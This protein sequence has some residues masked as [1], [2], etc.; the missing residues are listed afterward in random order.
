MIGDYEGTVLIVSH[1][2]DFLDR[3]VT[4]TLGL[5]GSGQV[6][7][8]AGGYEDWERRRRPRVDAKKPAKTVAAPVA[9]APARKLTYK[10]QR[11]Y[12][13]L[14]KRIE[15][16]DAA[17]ARDEAAMAD[18]D[19][20]VRD[21]KTFARLTDAIAKARADKD[22]AELRWL[23]EVW[24]CLDKGFHYRRCPAH[25]GGLAPTARLQIWRGRR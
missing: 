15:E 9:S 17:I 14:P 3:T 12:D 4:V 19:L 18:P 20:Y 16:L 21:P 11:D 13:L 7:I 23:D 6:D 25:Q 8:V 5:D 24:I 2:R 10:D 1:D 22:D